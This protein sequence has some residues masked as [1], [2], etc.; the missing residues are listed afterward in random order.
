L[1]KF[2]EYI[3]GKGNSLPVYMEA[4]ELSLRGAVEAQPARYVRRVGNQ[5]LDVKIK[6]RNLIKISEGFKA[7]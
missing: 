2:I 1:P 6:I 4:K 3:L 7:A 5:Q